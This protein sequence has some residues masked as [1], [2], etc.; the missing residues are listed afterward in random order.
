MAR[1]GLIAFDV[2]PEDLARELK[3]V[4]DESKMRTNEVLAKHGELR[5]QLTEVQQALAE[6][7]AGGSGGGFELGGSR[8]KAALS[9]VLEENASFKSLI[10]R[11]ADRTERMALEG[12]GIKA[13]VTLD[14]TNV[15]GDVG[16]P[17][18]VDRTPGLHG[19]AMRPLSLLDVL[20]VVPTEASKTEFVQITDDD[21]TAEV[22]GFEGD[23]KAEMGFGLQLMEAKIATIAVHTTVS[24]QVL[25]DT[26]DLLDQLDGLM[27]FK[28]RAAIEAQLLNGTGTGA[29][30]H[31]IYHQASVVSVD[32]ADG[33]E[34]ADNLIVQQEE[35]GRSPDVVVMH[36]RA[37]RAV[38]HQ[39]GSDGHYKHGDGPTRPVRPTI[40]NR[41]VVLTPLMPLDQV[42][43][44]VSRTARIRDRMAPTLYVSLDHK[45][46]RTR[47]LALLL[48]EARAG[49]ELLDAKSWV[50]ASI[51]AS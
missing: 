20:P 31:G 45:D 13:L 7:L 33:A 49:L 35:A 32:G 50:R 8:R 14:A 46:Y 16:Y 24:T 22:Q 41:P 39:T 44:G 12:L 40:A 17:G 26:A 25:M 11:R 6:K 23:E 36:P 34:R 38:T 48:V 51:T 37:W 2:S 43:V 42:M 10:E 29:N 4:I 9:Q 18:V 19:F 30:M 28:V 21:G 15:S 3:R 5:G 1:H 27:S 47:N